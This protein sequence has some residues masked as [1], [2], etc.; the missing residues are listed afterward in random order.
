MQTNDLKGISETLNIIQ[1]KYPCY[2]YLIYF[3][4]SEDFTLRRVGFSLVAPL[5]KLL[6]KEIQEYVRFAWEIE[7][8][9]GKFPYSFVKACNSIF[10]E[11]KNEI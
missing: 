6:P 5:F 2:N 9:K 10:F 1:E 8:K 7:T 11:E 3:M 4:Q